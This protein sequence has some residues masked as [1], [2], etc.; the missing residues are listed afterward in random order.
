MIQYSDIL[1]PIIN[2][3]AEPMMIAGDCPEVEYAFKEIGVFRLE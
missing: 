1:K 3:M 2:S